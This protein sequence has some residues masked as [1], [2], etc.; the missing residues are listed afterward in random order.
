[1]GYLFPKVSQL[2]YAKPGF[3][4]TSVWFQHCDSYMSLAIHGEKH[5]A[6]QNFYALLASSLN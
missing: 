4:P 1:M 2:A 5:L 6:H 3:D